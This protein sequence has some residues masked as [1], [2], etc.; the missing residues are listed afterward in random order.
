MVS[1][2]TPSF[3]VMARLGISYVSVDAG[4]PLDARRVFINDATN[5]VP[6]ENGRVWEFSLDV[7]YPVGLLSLQ[8]AYVFG[9]LR[10]SRF[11]GNFKFVGG[12]EDFD[13]KSNHWGLGGGLEIYFPVN[14]RFDMVLNGG[15][16]YLFSGRMT[17]HDT[18]YSPDGD[19]VNPRQ[20]YNY[21]DADA[22][23]GQPKLE[24]QFMLGFSYS[25]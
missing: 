24:P 9:G 8:Q 20:D 12:N 17:G 13:I 4:R 23:V 19:D 25:L 14:R 15:F 1:N 7:L 6:E 2:F 21:S 22:A 11:S 10:H 3:P 18:S 5:G 16:N